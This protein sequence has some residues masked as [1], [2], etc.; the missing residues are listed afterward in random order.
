M[1]IYLLTG[2]LINDMLLSAAFWGCS[3]VFVLFM[4]CWLPFLM[5]T[6][7]ILLIYFSF[8]FYSVKYFISHK[9]FCMDLPSASFSLSSPALKRGG[10]HTNG[11]CAAKRGGGGELTE[12]ILNN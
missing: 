11:S 9:M 4:W 2:L 5:K 10:C 7:L 6:I 12:S 8:I 1:F 3:P